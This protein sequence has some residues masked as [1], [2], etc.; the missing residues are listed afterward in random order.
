MPRKARTVPW[1][2][3][4]DGIAYAC[5]YDP[6]ALRTQRKSL[7]T[8]DAGEAQAKFAAFLAEGHAIYA[9]G[10]TEILTVA[11]ALDLYHAEHRQHTA[12]GHRFETGPASHLKRHLGAMALSDVDV[13]TC[14]EYARVRRL[15]AAAPNSI[16][17]EIGII[18]TAA[19]HCV[20]FKHLKPDA[21]PTIELP[22]GDEARDRWLTRE[23]LARLRASTDAQDTTDF[24]DLCYWT[25]SRKE[26]INQ[27]TKFQVD[28]AQ[29][30]IRLSKPGEKK[31]KKRRPIVPIVPE[32]MPVVKRLMET[33]PGEFLLPRRNYDWWFEKACRVAKIADATPHTLRHTRITH[34]LQDGANP[35]AVC[36]L[37]GLT[38]DTMTNV[39]GHHCPTFLAE[40]MAA[41]KVQEEA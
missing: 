32:L 34:L 24:I 37:A 20:K 7:H 11:Q 9:G 31:T 14:R 38:L 6:K 35:W 28:L 5:W 10:D 12:Q 21:L 40:I 16:R 25:A 17:G 36:G 19:R 29:Q 15:E 1:V 26:A 2:D 4:R 22:D 3:W 39:Y 33:T 30:R 27:L 8:R 13:P 23:E 18:Q 41:K